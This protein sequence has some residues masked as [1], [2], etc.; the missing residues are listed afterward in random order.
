MVTTARVKHS[1]NV[2]SEVI[3]APTPACFPSTRAAELQD[4]KLLLGAFHEY[5]VYMNSLVFT[6]KC[7]RYNCHEKP[8]HRVSIAWVWGFSLYGKGKLQV[9]QVF[10]QWVRAF[11]NTAFGHLHGLVTVS[12]Q[13]QDYSE[14]RGLYTKRTNAVLLLKACYWTASVLVHRGKIIEIRF[15]IVQIFRDLI[16]DFTWPDGLFLLCFFSF[17]YSS[18]NFVLSLRCWIVV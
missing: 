8:G 15:I 18:V 13:K 3:V 16:S 11:G 10:E 1:L 9:T 5:T 4:K 14:K 7:M 6:L 12:K 17:F 2:A